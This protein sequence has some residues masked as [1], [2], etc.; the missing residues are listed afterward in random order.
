MSNKDLDSVLRGSFNDSLLKGGWEKLK[1][2][3][4]GGSSIVYKGSIKTTNEVIAIKEVSSDGLSEDQIRGFMNEIMTIK[5]LQHKNIIRYIGAQK[6]KDRFYIFLDYA[7]RGSLRQFYLRN[8]PLRESQAANTTRQILKGLKYLH[9]NGIAHRDV[10]GANVLLCASGL[11]KLADFGA[12]KRIGS[13]SIVSGLKGTPQWMAPEVIKG[14]ISNVSWTMADIWS[15]GCT[16]IEMLTAS[17]PYAEYDNPMTAMYHIANG[18][19]PGVLEYTGAATDHADSN[20]CTVNS[21]D[22]DTQTDTDNNNKHLPLQPFSKDVIDFIKACMVVSPGSRCAASDLLSFVFILKASRKYR[23]QTTQAQQS[24]KKMNTKKSIDKNNKKIS[25]VDGIANNGDM[26]N[27]KNASDKER[28]RDIENIPNSSETCTVETLEKVQPTRSTPSES[29]QVQMIS[30]SATEQDHTDSKP[31]HGFANTKISA[32]SSSLMSP[33]HQPSS[34]KQTPDIHL[35]ASSPQEIDV[36]E[37]TLGETSASNECGDEGEVDGTCGGEAVHANITSN[38]DY[39]NVNRQIGTELDQPIISCSA[40]S[41][42][43]PPS[44]AE[45]VTTAETSLTESI[46]GTKERIEYQPEETTMA[47]RSRPRPSAACGSRRNHYQRSP[48]NRI[49]PSS[50]G[51]SHGAEHTSVDMDVEQHLPQRPDSQSH[52]GV[53]LGLRMET[54]GNHSAEVSV[55]DSWRAQR[56]SI[57]S[58]RREALKS[59]SMSQESEDLRNSWSYTSTQQIVRSG[60]S[61]ECGSAG[62]RTDIKNLDTNDATTHDLSDSAENFAFRDGNIIVNDSSNRNSNTMMVSSLT[63]LHQSNSPV[64]LEKGNQVPYNNV[65]YAVCST[66]HD[67]NAAVRIPNQGNKVPRR[68]KTKRRVSRSAGL[69]FPIP[70]SAISTSIGTTSPTRRDKEGG[71]SSLYEQQFDGI[72]TTG[73]NDNTGDMHPNDYNYHSTDKKIGLQRRGLQLEKMNLDHSSTSK[74]KCSNGIGHQS[75]HQNDNHSN[76]GP[77][78]GRNVRSAPPLSRLS[79]ISLPSL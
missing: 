36:P 46:E 53:P 38:M 52:H 23:E 21:T 28:C 37:A 74:N 49:A 59:L 16:V 7:D 8:G 66:S 13:E 77:L 65:G 12:S 70:L 72:H 43:S 63:S 14:N 75:G 26:K 35:L 73:I 40:P 51:N 34:C 48:N 33:S 18:N 5:D 68:D 1:V 9:N 29:C 39:I 6:E 31:V 20:I 42:L 32:T 45:A 47:M 2:V 69:P 78:I 30:Q 25:S 55:R 24:T 56:L 17:I 62:S 10:K 76:F 67:H 4:K 61:S 64:V 58:V 60:Y 15:V 79:N 57:D 11:M 22:N 19:L 3:G 54:D 41:S 50:N 71:I 27:R 44:S